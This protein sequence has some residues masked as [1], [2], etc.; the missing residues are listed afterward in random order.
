MVSVRIWGHLLINSYLFFY[1]RAKEIY[2]SLI[3]LKLDFAKIYFNFGCYITSTAFAPA[4]KFI[5]SLP[6]INNFSCYFFIC[7]FKWV[8]SLNWVFHLLEMIFFAFI[9]SLIRSCESLLC[10]ILKVIVY[11]GKDLYYCYLIFGVSCQSIFTSVK[12]KVYPKVEA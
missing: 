5:Y 8:I 12:E 9:Y 11:P 7:F 2:F 6:Q 1:L 4:L 3:F 10:E